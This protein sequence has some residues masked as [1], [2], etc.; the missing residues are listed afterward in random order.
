MNSDSI[1]ASSIC[2][3]GCDDQVKDLGI[4]ETGV[5]TLE[6]DPSPTDLNS[7]DIILTSPVEFGHLVINP[8]CGTQLHTPARYKVDQF[9][10]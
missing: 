1:T 2:D 6:E 8:R 5:D 9:L 7:E 4:E 10:H 3:S